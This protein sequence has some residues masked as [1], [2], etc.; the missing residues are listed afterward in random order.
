MMMIKDSA[1]RA[2]ILWYHQQINPNH[3]LYRRPARLRQVHNRIRT[4]FSGS[5]PGPELRLL[6]SS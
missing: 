5:L 3:Q 1:Q 2:V 6:L 4:V